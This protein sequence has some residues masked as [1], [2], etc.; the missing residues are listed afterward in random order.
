MSVVVLVEA[1]NSGVRSARGLPVALNWIVSGIAQLLG[2]AVP[3]IYMLISAIRA[4]RYINK[5]RDTTGVLTSR[6]EKSI[7]RLTRWILLSGVNTIAFL[8]FVFMFTIARSPTLYLW[9]G[10][11]QYTFV[12]FSLSQLMAFSH[13]ADAKMKQRVSV[14]TVDTG[15]DSST[16]KAPPSS[17]V[18]S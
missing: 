3:G 11:G 15:S 9:M 13:S 12:F 2:T 10:L 18:S 14:S 4:R 17:T 5:I 6:T 16:F 8:I 7:K 1:V